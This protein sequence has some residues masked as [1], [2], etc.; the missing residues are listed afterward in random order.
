M[1][2]TA[3]EKCRCAVPVSD[4]KDPVPQAV[5]ALERLCGE[6]GMTPV[7]IRLVSAGP[8][9]ETIGGIGR[10]YEE[11]TIHIYEATTVAA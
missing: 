3:G 1:T 2:P 6:H 10:P 7:D 8:W 5:E 11:I 9:T 4:D